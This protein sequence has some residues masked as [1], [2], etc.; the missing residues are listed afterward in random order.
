MSILNEIHTLGT[1]FCGVATTTP[2]AFIKSTNVFV[3]PCGRRR[4][5]IS[6]STRADSYIP[7]DIEARL[8]TEANIIKTS[9]QN[10]YNQSYVKGWEFDKVP[11][12]ALTIGGYNFKIKLD[13][14]YDNADNT[15]GAAIIEKLGDDAATKIYANIR[16]EDVQI[17]S[18]SS[19]EKTQV[20]RNQSGSSVGS[21][22]LDE[23]INSSTDTNKADS[24]YFAGLSFST[25]P[26]TGKEQTYSTAMGSVE[27]G[28]G[29]LVNQQ[30]YSLCI[31]SRDLEAENAS[32]ELYQRA[33]LPNIQ[34]G[35]DL[36]SVEMD[37]LYVNTLKQHGFSVPGVELI[38]ISKGSKYK[39]AFHTA[40]CGCDKCI[41][42][43]SNN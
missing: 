21:S 24:Y 40:S 36:N 7:F 13:N 29:N 27:I 5:I 2:L 20:L 11:T 22:S 25:I 34:H 42:Q 35:K 4:S 37:T 6:E 28:N 32:W 3:Y 41:V 16:I 14:N 1:N 9:A 38:E 10:G 43:V 23:L 18:G 30:I 12:L 33:L 17:T 26:I 31:L 8:S 15:L 39:L 19:T